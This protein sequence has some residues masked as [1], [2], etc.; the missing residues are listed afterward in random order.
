MSKRESI[1]RE[2][3]LEAVANLYE[4]FSG[5]VEQVQK[6]GSR[7]EMTISHAEVSDALDHAIKEGY[8]QAFFL[9]PQQPYYE[10]AEF[11]TDRIGELWFHVTAKGKTFVNHLSSAED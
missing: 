10:P 4:D 1:L 6:W 9:S 3:V 11:S 8:A 5:V 2:F 7:N